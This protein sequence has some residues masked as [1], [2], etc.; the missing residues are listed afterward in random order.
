[1]STDV[2]MDHWIRDIASEDQ[3]QARVNSAAAMMALTL[4]R[5]VAMLTAREEKKSASEFLTLAVNII[6][7]FMR[8]LSPHG[9]PIN[10]AGNLVFLGTVLSYDMDFDR[11]AAV[12]RQSIL[13]EGISEAEID[14]HVQRMDKARNAFFDN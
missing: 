7:E 14:A 2:P 1:M 5:T 10:V 12:L 4:V 3:R 6:T 9:A 13:D 8:E 11:A